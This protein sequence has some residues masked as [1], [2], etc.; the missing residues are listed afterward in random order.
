ML[1]GNSLPWCLVESAVESIV[2]TFTHNASGE[3]PQIV[4][5]IC[6]KTSLFW[7]ATLKEVFV[8][9]SFSSSAPNYKALSNVT[10]G[11]REDTDLFL[12]AC[13]S[14]VGFIRVYKKGFFFFSAG[15]GFCSSKTIQLYRRKMRSTN[16][17][18]FLREKLL[19][20]WEKD[21]KCSL[22]VLDHESSCIL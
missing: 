7:T 4:L 10:Q 8:K 17:R 5:L 22:K 20:S 18:V 12:Y 21:L 6:Y 13:H 14:L 16:R 11:H 1:S 9:K 2:T 19:F 3:I 15:W